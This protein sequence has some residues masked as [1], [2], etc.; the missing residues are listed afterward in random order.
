MSLDAAV[1]AE[2]DAAP[3]V[4]DR[5]RPHRHPP[6]ARRACAARWARSAAQAG[7]LNAP[8]RLRFDFTSPTGA[9][10]PAALAEIEDEV[11]SVLQ[12]NREVDLVRD[13]RWTRP[14]GSAR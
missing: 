11:N 14:G 9:V 6:G 5:S 12:E 8:G 13:S 2:V 4:G 3:A 7:S 10:A 1:V